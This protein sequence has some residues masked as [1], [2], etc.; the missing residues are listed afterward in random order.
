MD[1]GKKL[2]ISRFFVNYE[3]YLESLQKLFNEAEEK[4]DL[5][6]ISK[7]LLIMKSLSKNKTLCFFKR[8]TYFLVMFSETS[9]VYLLMGDKY[10]LFVFGVLEC[11]YNNNFNK[12]LIVF[13][14]D[15]PEVYQRTDIT[16]REYF[17]KI[18]KFHEIAK[19][20]NN[21]ILNII[22]LNYRLSYLRDNALG[23]F[24]DERAVSLI[25]QV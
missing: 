1:F 22:H 5:D 13:I 6:S 17:Q 24:L 19:I 14:I 18:V 20:Q 8:I 9:L 11:P 3:N 12:L 10:Y 7:I 23:F 25:T 4:S 2:Q 16:H 15:D 21:Q